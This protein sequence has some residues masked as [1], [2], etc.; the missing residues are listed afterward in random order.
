MNNTS[1]GG[2]SEGN[3][4]DDA[5]LVIR[6]C[7]FLLTAVPPPAKITYAATLKEALQ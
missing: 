3:A 5:L 6:E 4:A 2:A 7:G 1:Q